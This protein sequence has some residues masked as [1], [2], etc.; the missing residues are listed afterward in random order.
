MYGR[1]MAPKCSF[2]E[3]FGS[4]C[5]HGEI[6]S[7]NPTDRKCVNCGCPLGIHQAPREANSAFIQAQQQR[8]V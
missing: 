8:T 7:A 4:S 2:I 5:L 6:D 1:C 3:A